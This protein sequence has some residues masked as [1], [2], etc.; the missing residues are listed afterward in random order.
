VRGR[1]A[2]HLA[3]ALADGEDL[4]RVHVGGDDRRLAK[5]DAF[6]LT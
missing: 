6:A 2:Q 4:A 5:D 1:F 3:R